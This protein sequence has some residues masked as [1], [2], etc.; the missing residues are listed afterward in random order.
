[1]GGGRGV[2]DAPILR[3]PDEQI[4]GLLLGLG[5][6]IINIGFAIAHNHGTPRPQTY[7]TEYLTAYAQNGNLP[8]SEKTLAAY[9]PLAGEAASPASAVDIG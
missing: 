6:D 1:M 7:L 2:L 8:L 5:K 4:I 9:L 3:T